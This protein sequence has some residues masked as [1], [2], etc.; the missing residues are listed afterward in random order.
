MNILVTHK[1]VDVATYKMLGELSKNE[2]YTIYLTVPSASEAAKVEGKCIPLPISPITS[3][4]SWKVIKTLRR[5]VKQY[6]IDLIFSPSTSGLSNAL[7]A[8]IGTSVKNVG[9]RGTQAK[10]KKLDPTYYMGILNPRVDHIVCE[11][12]DIQEYLTRYIDKDK[13]SVS[14]KPFDI[15]WVADA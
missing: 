15:D 9:Y 11:T 12:A 14:V 5:Y 13:L 6:D 3:K 10:V 8:T 1:A 2:S 7:I 4:F